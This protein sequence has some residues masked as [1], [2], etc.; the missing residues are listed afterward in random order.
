MDALL[1]LR[2]G[3][4]HV[5]LAHDVQLLQRAPGG[6]SCRRLGR[7]GRNESRGHDDS[8]RR[9]KTQRQMRGD[10]GKD[11]DG[12]EGCLGGCVGY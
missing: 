2:V 11:D 5:V 1:G 8:K 7:R 12:S 10:D 4:A 3:R 9:E 6:G